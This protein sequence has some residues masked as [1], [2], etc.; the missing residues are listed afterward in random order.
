[1]SWSTGQ[2]DLVN[3]HGAPLCHRVGCRKH[4]RLVA[5]FQGRFCHRHCEE[6]RRIRDGIKNAIDKEMEIAS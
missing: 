1:M 6:L 5:A 2:F 3:I 4:K